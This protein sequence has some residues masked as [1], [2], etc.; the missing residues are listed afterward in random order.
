MIKVL[1]SFRTIKS[2]NSVQTEDAF[3]CTIF[4]DTKAEVPETAEGIEELVGNVCAPL[5]AGT[6]I[7][8][9]AFET[10]FVRSDG[11]IQWKGD[12]APTPPAVPATVTIT[13]QSGVKCR[14]G[15]LDANDDNTLKS[16]FY[17]TSG[18]YELTVPQNSTIFVV[19][20]DGAATG[21]NVMTT[22]TTETVYQNSDNGAPYTIVLIEEDTAITIG[23]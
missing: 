11:L 5:S 22:A 16:A 23:Y 8:T 14:V 13:M 12:P 20:G 6:L 19:P 7:I 1:D 17:T 2:L 9:S 3:V 4:A 15:Y 21:G 10:A 18:D